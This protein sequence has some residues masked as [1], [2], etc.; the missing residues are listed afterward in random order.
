MGEI[1]RVLREVTETGAEKT[2]ARIAYAS[3]EKA[4]AGATWRSSINEKSC[5]VAPLQYNIERH[6][7]GGRHEQT[8]AG[9]SWLEYTILTL[10]PISNDF[11]LV[12]CQ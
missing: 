7:G 2:R 1:C 4:E 5:I 6:G 3:A 12:H 8:M 11:S 9:W 10:P